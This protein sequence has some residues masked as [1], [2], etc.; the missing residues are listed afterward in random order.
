MPDTYQG[1]FYGITSAMTLLL[2]LILWQKS[3]VTIARADGIIFWLLRT[4]FLLCMFG[5][6]WGARALGSFD[7]LGVRPLMNYLGNR[8]EKPQEIIAKGP[9]RWLRHPLYFFLII[10]FWVCPVLTLDR[11]MF[12]SLWSIWIVIGTVL[13]DRDLH[14][15]FGAPYRE[16]SSKVP[17]IIPCRIPRK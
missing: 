4:I 5:F 9:Y 14:R 10:I 17:M 11:L 16:Y 1:A 6:F 8:Y 15:E 13:E 3:P 7:A 12:N 2:V